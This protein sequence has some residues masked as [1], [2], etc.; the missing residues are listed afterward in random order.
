MDWWQSK[1]ALAQNALHRNPLVLL[2]ITLHA[3]L[4]VSNRPICMESPTREEER[5]DTPSQILD[6]AQDLIQRRGYTAVS[7]GDLA[8]KLDLTTAAI[9][10]HFPSKPDLG[11]ALVA[12]YRQTN[13]E[14]RAAIRE[15]E[16]SPK[17]QLERYVEEYVSILES[18]GLCLCGVLATGDETLPTSV[19]QEV[20]GFFA[21]QEEWLTQVIANTSDDGRELPAYESPREIAELFLATIEGAMLTARDRGPENYRATL[22][23]LVDTVVA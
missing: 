20:H 7:Y 12:R 16:D 6:A 22:R 4:L 18:G 9:H 5:P 2:N 8:D 13:A 11:R 19:R 1:S 21:D 15:E 14:T 23:H 10:Y 3:Y 17:A